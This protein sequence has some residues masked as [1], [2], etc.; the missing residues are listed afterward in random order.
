MLNVVRI[1]AGAT[2]LTAADIDIAA[3]LDE[4]AREL[5]YEETRKSELTRIAYTYAR[6][7]RPCSVFGGRIYSLDNFSGPGGINANVK[8]EGINFFYDWVMKVNN[9]YNNPRKV[10]AAGTYRMS[11][12]HVL[13]PVP[14]IAITANTMGRINQNI[15]YPGAELNEPPRT[16]Q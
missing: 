9:F 7:G 15:G 2:P 11:V 4:R 8:Q 14:A 1:R 6:T 10:T 16:I 13:W 12:H 3:I 5:Y